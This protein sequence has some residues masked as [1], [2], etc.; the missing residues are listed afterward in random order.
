M[1]RNYIFEK[2]ENLFKDVFNVE[3][4]NFDNF[5]FFAFILVAVVFPICVYLTGKGL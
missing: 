2:E 4:S 5:S 3:T 1:T